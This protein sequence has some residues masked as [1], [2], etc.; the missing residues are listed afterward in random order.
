MYTNS[1]ELKHNC[2]NQEEVLWLIRQ[3][4]IVYFFASYCLKVSGLKV[5]ACNITYRQFVFASTKSK[6]MVCVLHTQCLSIFQLGN[7]LL[8]EPK[9]QFGEHFRRR[10]APERVVM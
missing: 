4:L 9:G 3:L 10:D 8:S 2:N 1:L 5:E 6:N 7:N